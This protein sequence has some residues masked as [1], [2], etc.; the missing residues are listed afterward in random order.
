MVEPASLLGDVVTLGFVQSLGLFSALSEVVGEGLPEMR[1]WEVDDYL[2]PSLRL[3]TLFDSLFRP[4]A[5]HQLH[6]VQLAWDV[7]S[8]IPAVFAP[9][10]RGLGD[11]TKVD[12]LCSVHLL[13]LGFINREVD[14]LLRGDRLPDIDSLL[15]HEDFF[16]LAALL[17]LFRQ[18]FLDHLILALSGSVFWS[19][20]LL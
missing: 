8:P 10:P 3:F 16:T 14:A 15:S 19:P 5:G 6:E 4:F 1:V 9:V 2:V 12:Y 7:E 11:E 20:M 13:L 18:R 17:L